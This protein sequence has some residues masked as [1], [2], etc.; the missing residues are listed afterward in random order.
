MN[1]QSFFTNPHFS[2]RA[3]NDRSIVT[4]TVEAL[5]M[6]TSSFWEDARQAAPTM[7]EHERLIAQLPSLSSIEVS[8]HDATAPAAETGMLSVAAWNAE[9]LK[10]HTG[11]VALLAAHQ[12]DILLLTEADI[13][14][15]R[16][17]NRHTVADL[18]R[19]L[20][21]SY[22]Y[23]VEFVEM[24]LGDRREREWHKHET[25]SIGFHGNAVLSR[26]PLLDAALIR[27]DDG[28]VW[29]IDETDGQGRFGSRMAIATRI[30]TANRPIV[31]VAAHLE[32]KSDAEDRARQTIRL[33][34]AID[35]LAGDLPV[36]IGGDF[37]TN[38]LPDGTRDP[39]RFEPL[40]DALTQKGYD[41]EAAND[42]AQTQRIRPDGTPQPPFARLDWIFTRGF[43]AQEPQTVA[44][45][46]RDGAAISDHELV[47][48]TLSA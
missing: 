6:P 33:L 14:M 38:V 3:G 21:M 16:S 11:S 37:N 9:R 1:F 8:L 28:G 32:S 36:V 35:K 22:A 4:Q 41:W 23:G 2:T 13:G 40:F 12:P 42:F 7:E 18:A 31:A 27:L 45:I 47:V 19:D 34:D 46:D 10:Y 24:G 48:A 17:G 15:A 44:A 26:L 43:T 5:D 30:E 25:N 20:G 39:A 29:W